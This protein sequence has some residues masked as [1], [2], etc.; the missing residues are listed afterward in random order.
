[1]F[2]VYQLHDEPEAVLKKAV[3]FLEQDLALIKP[4]TSVSDSELIELE[5]IVS[6][7]KMVHDSCILHGR[8]TAEAV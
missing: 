8:L 2:S 1:M 3:S 4:T 7:A 6:H 5:N